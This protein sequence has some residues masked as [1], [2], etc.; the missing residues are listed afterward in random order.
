MP[1]EQRGSV[2]RVKGGYGVRWREGSD[3]SGNEIRRRH[4]PQPPFPTKTAAR[5]WYAENIAARLRTGG[6][7]GDITFAEFTELYL[8]AHATKVDPRTIRTLRERLGAAAPKDDVNPDTAKETA[9]RGRRR[10]YRSALEAFGPTSLREL[11]RGSARIAAWEATLPAGYRSKL[12]AALSQVLEVAVEWD[13]ITRNPARPLRRRRRAAGSDRRPEIVPLTRDQVDRLAS[14]LGYEPAHGRVSVYGVAV[15]FAAETG[16]RPE[17]W[18]ALERRDLDLPGRAVTVARAFSDGRLKDAKTLGSNRRVPLS[19]RA[20]DAL[21]AL[22]PRLDR[23]I[24]FPAPKG[25]Y[26]DLGNFRRRVWYPAL[27]SGGFVRCP[28]SDDHPTKRIGREYRCQEPGCEGR[29]AVHRIYD[30]RHTF[31]SWALAAHIS[32]FEL[33]RFMGTSVK[34]IDRHYGHLVRDSEDAVRAKL[35]AYASSAR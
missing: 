23:R 32:I 26:I 33:A 6:P 22:P 10:S 9:S 5:Q 18:I 25:G 16:L 14:E 11:E 27:E 2:Y 8:A 3:A 21:E 12:T 24:L 15:V 4:C 30:L 19:Q 13:Y 1:A 17:E 34:I 7:V 28:V 20:L 35:D 31:A 29:A